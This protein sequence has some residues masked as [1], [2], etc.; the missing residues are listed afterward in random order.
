MRSTPH[1]RRVKARQGTRSIVQQVRCGDRSAAV[2]RGL[3]SDEGGQRRGV[4]VG[5]HLEDGPPVAWPA[6][7]L[8]G[9]APDQPGE[10]G[11]IGPDQ[12]D[13]R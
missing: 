12:D 13:A 7:R 3:A 4:S 1:H 5:Q 6:E 9:M 11:P 10:G 2:Q 8:D